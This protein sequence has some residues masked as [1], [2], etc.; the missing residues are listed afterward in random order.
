MT[1]R[2]TRPES[3]KRSSGMSKK[4]LKK[5]TKSLPPDLAELVRQAPDADDPGFLL[6]LARILTGKVMLTMET[7]GKLNKRAKLEDRA[8]NLRAFDK[9]IREDID[10]IRRLRDSSV[11]TETEDDHPRNYKVGSMEGT[12]R[13]DPETGE[14]VSVAP[15]KGDLKDG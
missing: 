8:I 15:G 4:A 9:G 14:Y 10:L 2:G 11:T 12:F 6:A 7:L 5:L 3:R 1:S 13:R